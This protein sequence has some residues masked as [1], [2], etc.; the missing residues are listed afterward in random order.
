MKSQ[1]KPGAVRVK[2]PRA[3]LPS[4][5]LGVTVA[6]DIGCPLL[7]CL[8]VLVASKTHLWCLASH[9]TRCCRLLCPLHL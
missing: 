3:E 8:L 5:L 1:K 7:F 2:D 9:W 6:G 4:V